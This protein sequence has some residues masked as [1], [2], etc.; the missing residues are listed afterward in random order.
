[1]GM[2]NKNVIFS[3]TLLKKARIFLLLFLLIGVIGCEKREQEF[4]LY[5]G[6]GI[7][8]PGE[9]LVEIFN[10]E[11]G[12]RI[13]VDYAGSETL[14]TKITITEKGDLYMPGDKHYVD[15][16]VA[17]GLVEYQKSVCYFVPAILVQKGN[18]REI[19]TLQDLLKPGLKLGLGDA[20]ACAIGRKSVKIFEKN[21]IA[22]S[23]VEKNLKYPSLT[24]NELGMQIETQ[25]LDAVIV[26][27]A[28]ARYYTQRNKAEMIP[29]PTEQ[30]IISTID[31]GLLKSTKNKSMA[32]RFIDFIT[33][34]RGRKIFIQHK[35]TVEA[36]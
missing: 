19:E 3:K 9:E 14:L 22:W 17:A 6:A 11:H 24:V 26:W 10:Q 7:K 21:G 30:N 35:Y 13:A 12:V 4:L 8:P 18:P 33:S 34:E 20:Q 31:I 36:P 2:R 16:A 27:D 1:M 5:C 29:I 32:D 23:E 15:Q 28:N 25:M